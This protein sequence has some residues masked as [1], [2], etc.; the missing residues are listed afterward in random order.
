VSYFAAP[1][2]Y[3][4]AGFMQ[5]GWISERLLY[6]TIL[7]LPA[8][9]IL[10]WPRVTIFALLLAVI[11]HLWSTT[12]QIAA[13]D[14]FIKNY[15][16]CAPLIRPHSL[17]KTYYPTTAVSPQVTPTLHLTAYLA[18]QTDVVDLDDYE[19][20]LSD[21]PVAYRAHMPDRPP[22]YVIAWKRADLPQMIGYRVVCETAT[23]RLLTHWR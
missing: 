10:P 13:I 18:L 5:A 16:Q 22:D 21:F 1:W 3:A 4:S 17:L 20:D 14:G 9:I 8:W 15:M 6:L 12:T 19:A 7:T 11:A 23:I 2:S